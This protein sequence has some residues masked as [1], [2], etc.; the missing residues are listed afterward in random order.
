MGVDGGVQGSEREGQ[1]RGRSEVPE[2]IG[3][4]RCHGAEERDAQVVRQR[5][6]HLRRSRQVNANCSTLKKVVHLLD[7]DS[8][9]SR[10]TRATG[11]NHLGSPIRRPACCAA[12]TR[13]VLRARVLCCGHACCVGAVQWKLR[14]GG[15]GCAVCCHDQRGAHH[16]RR[17]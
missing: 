9:E 2:Q 6:Q 16:R 7:L 15:G 5:G 13:A 3:Q 14:C 4:R 1:E 17:P 8:C 12:G 10:A 11:V